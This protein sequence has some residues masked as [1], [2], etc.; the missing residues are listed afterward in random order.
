MASENKKALVFSIL[1][2]LQK[3]CTDGTIAADDSEGIE[4]AMQC[5]GEAFGVDPSDEAQQETYSTKPANLLSIFEVYLK[6]KSK[7]KGP[8]PAAAATSSQRK[9]FSL[10]I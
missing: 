6:T 2:F 7:S 3:S 10:L 1:E 9:S 4:V 5:I 8:S